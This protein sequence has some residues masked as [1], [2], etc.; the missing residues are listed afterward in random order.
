MAKAKPAAGPRPRGDSFR[1]WLGAVV[2]L[3][4]ALLAAFLLPL[5]PSSSSSVSSP[6]WS[7]RLAALA[8]PV[9]RSSATAVAA[10]VDTDARQ[11]VV[12]TGSFVR[13]WPAAQW[14]P[15]A[16][17]KKLGHLTGIYRNTHATF[18]PYFDPQRPMASSTA[19]ANEYAT[20]SSMAAADFFAALERTEA[21][22][23]Y[24]STEIDHLGPWALHDISPFDEFIKLLSQP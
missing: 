12:V 1:P 13:R 20:N 18:G 11:P 7:A 14:T 16:L 4:A 23:I 3:A 24:L 6:A 19:P 2:L 9:K 22:Y 21:P 15:A 5:L 10:A 17:A 8:T